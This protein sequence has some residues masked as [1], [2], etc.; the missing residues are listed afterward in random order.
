MWRHQREHLNNMWSTRRA[1]D[2]RSRNTDLH[3]LI[4]ILEVLSKSPHHQ[5]DLCIR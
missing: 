3:H 4:I 1:E 5:L 2:N